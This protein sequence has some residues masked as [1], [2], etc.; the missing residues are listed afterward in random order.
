MKLWFGLAAAA[1]LGVVS[2]GALAP[3]SSMPD[4]AKQYAERRNCYGA[5]DILIE[6][7]NA[8]R[9]P[10]DGDRAWAKSYEQARAAKTRCPEPP[11]ALAARATNRV[12]ATE[13]GYAEL[14]A[15]LPQED[16][17][18]YFEAGM[19]GLSGKISDVPPAQGFAMLKKAADLGDATARM[20][21]GSLHIAGSISGKPDYV[22]GLPFIVAAADAGH[23]DALFMAGSFYQSGIGT[24]PDLRKAFEYYRQ[25]AERGHTYAAIMAFDM[26]NEGKGT[27]KDFQLAYRLG[28]NLADRGEAYGAVMAASAL[29]QQKSATEHEDEV[30]YW[31]DAAAR[32]GDEKIRQHVATVRPQV[33]AAYKRANAPP[34][35]RPRQRKLCPLKTTCMVNSFT[36]LRSCTT[37][38]DYW[39]D[40]DG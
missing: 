28:R 26:I 19:A 35:Y 36:N 37:N 38:V 29:L 16:P 10:S 23:V 8:G 6:D 3:A 20:V 25:A 1:A 2:A 30:L 12:V 34:E 27:K 32:T 22:A 14:A 33:V 13:E 39:N 5:Y 4:L 18:A 9:Q 21:I 24:K 7:L 15:Y 31:L 40:C 11:E 17:V